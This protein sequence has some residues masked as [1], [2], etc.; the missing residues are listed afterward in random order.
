MKLT[1][2]SAVIMFN[3][4]EKGQPWPTP[5][6]RVNRSDSLPFTLILDWI[7]RT[8][9]EMNCERQNPNQI[10]QRFLFYLSGTSICHE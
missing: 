1:S 6:I 5:H 8:N 9:F 2:T 4:I 7:L 10:Y 3:S